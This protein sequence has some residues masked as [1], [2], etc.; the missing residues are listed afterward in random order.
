MVYTTYQEP[1]RNDSVNVGLASVTISEA[2]NEQNP[3]KVILIRN[4]SPNATDIITVAF[5]A[6]SAVANTGVVLRQNE[7]V[8]DSSDSGYT[9]YQGT[10]NA[11]CATA[12]G[13][14]AIME[15]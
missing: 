4:I 3:R 6:V 7:S 15:R 14:V 13:V 12:T 8:S 9:P 2:R 10:I 5:G 1:T 11:I